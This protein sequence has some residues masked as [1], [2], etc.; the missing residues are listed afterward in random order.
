MKK[1]KIL[2]LTLGLGLAVGSLTGTYTIAQANQNPAGIQ[3]TQNMQKGHEKPMFDKAN[4]QEMLT[5]LKID[6]QTF[7]QEKDSGKSLAEI[8]EAHNVSRQAVVDLVVKN[9]NKQIDTR[10][11]DKRITVE[12]ANEMKTNAVEKAQQIVDGQL[13]GFDKM[14]NIQNSQEML[15]LL[16][17]D[18]QTFKQEANSG[19][20]LAEIAVAHNVT[21]QAVVDLIVKNMNQQVDKGLADKRITAEQ[22]NEM[23]T[24]AVEKAQ[25]IVDGQLMGSDKMHNRQVPQE[26]LTLLKIDEQTFKQEVDSGKSL[27]E[28]AAAHNVSKQAVV[29]L[30]V[31]NM[32]QQIDKGLADKRLTVEQANEMKTN[33]VEKAQQMVDVKPMGF[34]KMN[35]PRKNGHEKPMNDKQNPQG[36]NDKQKS[37]DANDKQNPQGVNDKQNSQDVNK[38]QNAQEMLTLLKIDEQTFEQEASSGKSLVQIAATHN[39]SRQAVV[40]L[41]TKNMNEQIDQG[42]AEKRITTEQATEMKTSAVEKIQEMVDKNMAEQPTQTTQPAQPQK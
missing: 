19:K 38:Q 33:A 20:S 1:K 41:V 40:D 39:V 7:K 26:M 11:A 37:Q 16:K 24:N 25:Q 6:E 27:T 15:T 30:I 10:L 32:N 14:H 2:A 31:K 9:M 36:V 35:G 3:N 42:L 5:L 8:A 17:I 34:D 28:I 4:H 18:A 13:M 22:A 12:Q 29:D 21:R 23:K